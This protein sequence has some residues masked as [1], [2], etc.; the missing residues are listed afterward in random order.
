MSPAA[1]PRLRYWQ[2]LPKP[3]QFRHKSKLQTLF[4]HSFQEF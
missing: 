4:F 1:G 2:A 3:E